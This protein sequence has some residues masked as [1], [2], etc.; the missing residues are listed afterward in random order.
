M[1]HLHIEFQFIVAIFEI[2]IFLKKIWRTQMKTRPIAKS[3][4]PY[5]LRKSSKFLLYFLKYFINLTFIS[6][7]MFRMFKNSRKKPKKWMSYRR[8]D[9]PTQWPIESRSTR[10][11]TAVC[12]NGIAVFFTQ[13]STSPFNTLLGLTTNRQR[14]ERHSSYEYWSLMFSQ[15]LIVN[16][17]IFHFSTDW[18]G[19]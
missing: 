1:S 11:R 19:Y 15:C 13:K 17:L 9:R 8:T 2:L 5:E 16:E 14:Q 6:L 12:P 3:R 10:L 7:D 18:I 4:V